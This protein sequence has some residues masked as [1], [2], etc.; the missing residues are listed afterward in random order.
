M[1]V[2]SASENDT[3]EISEGEEDKGEGSRVE[4]LIR[5][6]PEEDD[7]LR[8]VVVG[9]NRRTR[10]KKSYQDERRSYC[11]IGR[12]VCW[13]KSEKKI[14]DTFIDT[15]EEA[16]EDWTKKGSSRH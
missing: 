3:L 1:Q 7:S 5:E 8:E 15:W 6:E 14:Q 9:S 16:E 10:K 13:T 2:S 4:N 11:S 12:I